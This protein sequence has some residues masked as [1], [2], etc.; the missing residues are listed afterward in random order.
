MAG[1]GGF[2]PP[3]GGT[4]TRCLTAWRQPKN[5]IYGGEGEI[6]TL[7]RLLTYIRLAG[8]RLQPARPPLRRFFPLIIIHLAENVLLVTVIKTDATKLNYWRRMRDSNPHGQNPAVFKTAALPIRTN[9]PLRLHSIQLKTLLSCFRK[10][11]KAFCL[12][13]RRRFFCQLI[14][15]LKIFLYK[16]QF[17]FVTRFPHQRI[18]GN[19]ARF[20]SR[21]V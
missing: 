18:S 20:H 2:E 11:L 12:S 6:R 7:G 17:L 15:F 14:S 19:L 1:L 8:V 10:E 16:L 21:L 5:I 9:P 4:K 3:D 13:I